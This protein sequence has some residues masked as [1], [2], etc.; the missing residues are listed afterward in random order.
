[1]MG[2]GRD[3]KLCIRYAGRYEVEDRRRLFRQRSGKEPG[4]LSEW[5]N[6]AAEMC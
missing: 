5:R 6:S 3:E 4:I 1:M 2:G